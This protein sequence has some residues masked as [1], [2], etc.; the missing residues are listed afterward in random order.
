[1]DSDIDDE[2]KEI[3]VENKS[4]L[5]IPYKEFKIY[6]ELGK[7]GFATVFYAGCANWT[8]RVALKLIHGSNR[9]RKEFIKEVMF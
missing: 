6:Q 9:N 8:K 1:M 4:L 2:L 3:F 7:G 5:W